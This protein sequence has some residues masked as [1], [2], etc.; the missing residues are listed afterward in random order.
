MKNIYLISRNETH[1][2]SEIDYLN[3]DIVLVGN[4][5]F[6]KKTGLWMRWQKDGINERIY[7][8][9]DR[10]F[11]LKVKGIG[12]CQGIFFPEN[13]L[14]EEVYENILIVGDEDELKSDIAAL[15]VFLTDGS[16]P[17]VFPE[18][19]ICKMVCDVKDNRL[20]ISNK[21]F[22]YSSDSGI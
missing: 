10:K 6:P 7:G 20:K 8:Q 11:G 15:C 21:G 4:G 14:W 19:F 3:F 13:W 1:M 16:K 22:I 18:A 2:K 12:L 5:Y 17:K 9:M